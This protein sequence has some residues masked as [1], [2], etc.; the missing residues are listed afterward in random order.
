[1]SNDSIDRARIAA[2]N[3]SQKLELIC[4]RDDVTGQF[5][6]I[7]TVLDRTR[8]AD[9]VADTY[10]MVTQLQ[11]QDKRPLPSRYRYADKHSVWVVATFNPRS[12][13]VE[14]LDSIEYLY[15]FSTLLPVS[16]DGKEDI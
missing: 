10:Q 4:V 8:W 12:G 15:Q 6:A 13:V 2:H 11:A 5:G 3:Q 7:E 16:D 9:L 1:M 14:P